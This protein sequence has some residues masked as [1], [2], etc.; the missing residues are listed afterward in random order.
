MNLA[1]TEGLNNNSNKNNGYNNCIAIVTTQF[2]Y[3]SLAKIGQ[4]GPVNGM[5]VSAEESSHNARKVKRVPV[6]I[7]FGAKRNER[8]LFIGSLW[9]TCLALHDCCA[10]A[11][12]QCLAPSLP[13]LL[14]SL[15]WQAKQW[16]SSSY[17]FKVTKYL[18]YLALKSYCL[19]S[20]WGFTFRF[21]D[22]SRLLKLNYDCCCLFIGS[23]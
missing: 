18:F 23:Q 7:V 12:Y 9:P 6:T 14:Y 2:H 16:Q 8:F 1:K 20:M 22:N 17:K 4:S 21:C 3:L 10:V 19:S 15:Y 11:V 13:I 5:S